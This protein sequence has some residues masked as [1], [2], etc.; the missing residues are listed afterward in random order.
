MLCHKAQLLRKYLN[1]I[2]NLQNDEILVREIIDIDT[3]Y[4]EMKIQAK[5][6]NK[7]LKMKQQ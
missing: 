3:N 6:R 1:G 7:K 4:M 2:K 5:V